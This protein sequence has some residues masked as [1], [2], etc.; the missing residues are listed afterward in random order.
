MVW[1]P[2]IA[3][4]Y[5]LH[6]LPLQHFKLLGFSAIFRLSCFMLTCFLFT[7]SLSSLL[8]VQFYP[9][10]L[11]WVSVWIAF[12]RVTAPSNLHFFYNNSTFGKPEYLNTYPWTTFII[13]LQTQ[14]FVLVLPLINSIIF[15]LMIIRFTM[16]S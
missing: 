5:L 12:L 4:I 7:V 6:F 13:P 10:A 11:S 3:Y 8:P 1:C 9:A 2:Y 16:K 15:L 14:A